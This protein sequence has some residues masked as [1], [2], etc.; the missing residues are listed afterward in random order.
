MT[1]NQ[2]PLQET[3][4]TGAKADA[5][6]LPQSATQTSGTVGA[7]TL[8]APPGLKTNTWTPAARPLS[9]E[10]AGTLKSHA[11]VATI[12]A[13]TFAFGES[14][15]ACMASVTA[16]LTNNL[17]NTSYASRSTFDSNLPDNVCVPLQRHF[18]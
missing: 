6:T 13:S 18:A 16:T 15:F 2:S 7:V 10:S 14:C 17:E 3:L 1:W 8:E 4:N 11:F 12:V 5:G 9:R